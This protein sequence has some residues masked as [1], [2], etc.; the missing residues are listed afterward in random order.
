MRR[1]LPFAGLGGVGAAGLHDAAC[2]T[3]P[4]AVAQHALVQFASR[5]AWQLL[6]E[7]DRARAF[8]VRE[9]LAAERNQF[10]GEFRVSAEAKIPQ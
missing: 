6:L 2:V 3:G 9:M 1:L 5:Q 10:V 4:I 8:Q 7:I